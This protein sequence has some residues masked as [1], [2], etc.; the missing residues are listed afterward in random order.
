MTD[1]IQV[2]KNFYL[3][4]F[5]TSQT[6]YRLKI[7]NTPPWST[8]D[9]IKVLAKNILQPVREHFDLPVII[10]SGYR[11]PALNR[12]IGGSITSQHLTG[13]AVD[14]EIPSISNLQVAEWIRDNLSFDQ[15]ILEFWNG[16]NTGWIHCS[17]VSLNANRKQTLTINKNGTFKGF[18][19]K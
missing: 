1:N 9:N 10:S 3:S 12:T 16:G 4:E 6:A 18:R 13:Q 8:V 5:L 7:D 11:S 14:F 15:L 19:A 17:F 2:S